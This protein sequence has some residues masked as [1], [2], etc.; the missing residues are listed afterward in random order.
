MSHWSSVL[1]P[2]LCALLPEDEEAM[3]ISC[4]AEVDNYRA[5]D[6]RSVQASKELSFSF[7]SKSITQKSL[8]YLLPPDILPK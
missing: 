5:G 3:H 1:S 7:S 8:D 2:R 4:R 6:D